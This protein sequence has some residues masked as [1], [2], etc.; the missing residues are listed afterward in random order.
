LPFGTV[1]PCA[2]GSSDVSI[3]MCEPVVD[4]KAE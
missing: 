4:G 1:T 3:D 2:H